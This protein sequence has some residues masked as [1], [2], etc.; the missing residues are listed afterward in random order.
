MT[1]PVLADPSGSTDKLYD[2]TSR[3]RPT[4]VLLGPGAEI[5]SIGSSAPSDSTIEAV[6]PIAYP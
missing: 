1:I 5:L 6:L 2:P 4:Y 3:S